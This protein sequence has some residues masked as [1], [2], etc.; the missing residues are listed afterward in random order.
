MKASVKKEI[1]EIIKKGN[2]DCT[3]RV[4][5]RQESWFWISKTNFLKTS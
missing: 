4:L 3:I 5:G 1:E 2:Y